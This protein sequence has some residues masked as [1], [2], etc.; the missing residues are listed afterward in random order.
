ML[1]GNL[2]QW[3]NKSMNNKRC[4]VSLSR[5]LHFSEDCPARMWTVTERLNPL[6]G[7][8][9]FVVLGVRGRVR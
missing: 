9:G 4:D 2:D 8:R 3:I 5:K 1:M 7:V 6:S